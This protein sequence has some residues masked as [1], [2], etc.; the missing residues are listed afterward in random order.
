MVL[1]QNG[2]SARKLGPQS[3]QECPRSVVR[4]EPSEESLPTAI[5]STFPQSWSSHSPAK[6]ADTRCPSLGRSGPGIRAAILVQNGGLRPSAV[7][8]RSFSCGGLECA[9]SWNLSDAREAQC[10]IS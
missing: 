5:S 2:H 10:S 7:G 3:G 4:S 1:M 6:R 9:T 8:Q